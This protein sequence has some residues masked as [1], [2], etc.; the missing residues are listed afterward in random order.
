MVAM[1]KSN[2]IS[3]QQSVSEKYSSLAR[4]PSSIKETGVSRAFL[5]ELVAKHL[6]ENGILDLREL[7]DKVALEWNVLEEVISDLRKE[8]LIEVKG[9]TE[10]T[11]GL[12]YSLTDKG[13]LFARKAVDKDGYIGYAPV[14][15]EEYR[16]IIDAQ[17]VHS[18]IIDKARL[19]EVFSGVVVQEKLLNQLGAAVNSNQAIFV[20]GP[21]GTGK[22]YLCGKLSKAFSSHILIPHAIYQDGAVVQLYDPALHQAINYE[23]PSA[24]NVLKNTFDQRYILCERPVIVSGGELSIDQLEVQVDHNTKQF[25]APLQLK[26]N[27]G[28][29]II[30]DLGRQRVEPKELFNRWIVPLETQKDYLTVSNGKRMEVPF[31]VVLVFST[32]LNPL[33]LADDAFLRRIGHKVR[34]DYIDNEEYVQI[35]KQVCDEFDVN[36]SEENIGYIFNQFYDRFEMPKLPCHPRDLIS[37]ALNHESYECGE[38]KLTNNALRNAW[39]NYFIN[40]QCVDDEK[41]AFTY[42]FDVV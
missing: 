11:T 13:H 42:K 9:P 34:F 18:E 16:N 15:I 36:Y 23:K 31:D 32:N 24:E 5:N 19:T 2:V 33:E 21:P 14:P 8:A 12:R 29:Y 38:R 3:L 17:K 20:Y 30:D 40:M 7:V 4:S 41:S 1:N 39:L 6:Y 28:I 35:W 37:M 22:S 26:A 10:N 25:H 27:N